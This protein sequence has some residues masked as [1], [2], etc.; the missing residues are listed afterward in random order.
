MSMQMSD[1]GRG[2]LTQ[3]EGGCRT[4][5]YDDG[6][7][8]DTI[9][10]G[11]A[12][13]AAEKS[14]SALNVDGTSVPYANGITL[15]QGEALL[16]CDLHRFENALNDAIA[17]DLTQN[18]FDALVSFSFNVGVAAFQ[19]S[20]VLRDVNNS[21]LDAVPNDLRMWEKAGGVFN[22]GLANR[23]ENEIRLWLGQI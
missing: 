6:V 14:A 2:L 7:G 17:V 23:R 22:Q 4:R 5:V 1:H 21:N 8:V 3:W 9:G 15:D 19:G 20:S 10:V 16:A 18:Q 11:H 12:L 13:T